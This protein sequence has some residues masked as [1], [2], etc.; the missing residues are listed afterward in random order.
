MLSGETSV[1][2]YPIEAVRTMVRIIENV[3][4][5]GGDRIAPLGSYPQTRGGAITRAAA[6]M[7]DQLEVTHLVTFKSLWCARASSSSQASCGRGVQSAWGR[8]SAPSP[9]AGGPDSSG[10]A[11]G[12]EAGRAGS[13]G[14]A[15]S[16][17]TGDAGSGMAAGIS[18]PLRDV[19]DGG[20]GTAGRSGSASGAAARAASSIRSPIRTSER[21]PMN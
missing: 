1:G 5:N 6:E 13:F 15:G 11:D 3:E 10:R 16:T 2:A 7:G 4:D 19:G 20:A 8:A 12:S 21:S 9:P 18:P 17:G 14:A